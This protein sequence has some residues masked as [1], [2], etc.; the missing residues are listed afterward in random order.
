MLE[1]FDKPFRNWFFTWSVSLFFRFIFGVS[2]CL[3]ENIAAQN[4]IDL[5]SRMRW[6]RV[7]WFS[8]VDDESYIAL[9]LRVFPF[10]LHCNA[11]TLP[12]CIRNE[13]R[14]FINYKT[15]TEQKFIFQV[16]SIRRFQEKKTSVHCMQSIIKQ[17]LENNRFH[18]NEQRVICFIWL[19]FRRELF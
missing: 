8:Q 18:I 15:M 11:C 2:G 1:G 16:R 9:E 19:Y 6:L 3:S 10:L 13:W 7:K 4:L 12:V 14:S 5:V 17:R